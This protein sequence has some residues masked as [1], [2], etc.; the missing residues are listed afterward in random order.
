MKTVIRPFITLFYRP[1]SNHQHLEIGYEKLLNTNNLHKI[2]RIIELICINEFKNSTR[3]P[4]VSLLDNIDCAA[5]S[6]FTSQRHTSY[7]LRAIAF[8]RAISSYYSGAGNLIYPLK[9]EWQKVFLNHGIKVN[10]IICSLLWFFYLVLFSF[11]EIVIYLNRFS[12][13]IKANFIKR[14]NKSKLQN[15]LINVYFYD[16]SKRNLPTFVTEIHE[17][18]LVTWYKKTFRDQ[19]PINVVHNVEDFFTK[20]VDKFGYQFTYF[21][22]LFETPQVLSEFKNLIWFFKMILNRSTNF[23]TK[24]NLIS[25]FNEILKAKFAQDI[26]CDLKLHTVVF[27]NSIGSIKPLWSIV[28]EENDIEIIFCFYSSNAEPSDSDGNLPIDGFWKLAV[29]KKIYVLDEYQKSQILDQTIIKP[30]ITVP[31]EIPW[32][33]DSSMT[34]PLVSKKTICLFDT[35]L[36]SN[37]YSFGHLNQIGWYKPEIAIEF[38]STVLEIANNLNMLVFYKLKR[39]RDKN[40]RNEIHWNAIHNLSAEFKETIIQIDDAIAPKRLIMNCTVTISK[41]LSTTALIAQSAHKPSLYYDPTKK[42]RFNDPGVRGIPVLNNKGD[43]FKTIERL[44]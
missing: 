25:N 6:L 34:L 36:H 38:L 7:L 23:Q 14:K 20:S 31:N 30:S 28:L 1:N 35:V 9:K 17:Q 19:S 16:I 8:N 4:K 32:W 43:L 29:W 15:D 41:P 33:S 21:K 11:K 22:D 10:Q 39:I 26:I 40:M 24:L 18:N 13:N 44:L 5:L 12:G 3:Q 42:I 27:N 2:R 37:L